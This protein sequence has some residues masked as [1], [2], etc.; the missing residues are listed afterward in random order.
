MRV[1]V[2]KMAVVLFAASAI[3][4]S[5]FASGSYSGGGIRPPTASKPAQT[6]GQSKTKKKKKK[7]SLIEFRIGTSVG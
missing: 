3:S 7:T 5:A 4:S 6:Q 2:G 1:T